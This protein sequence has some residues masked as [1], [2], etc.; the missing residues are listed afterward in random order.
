MK[1]LSTYINEKLVLNKNTF[2][3]VYKYFPETKEELEDILKQLIEERKD[4]D[5]IDLNDIDTSKIID[6]SQLFYDV[7]RKVN[8]GNFKKID[9]SE[10]NVSNVKNMTYM[11]YNCN[12]L[13]YIGD[14]SEWD[15]SKVKNMNSMFYK[16]IKLKYIGDLSSWDVSNVENMEAMFYHCDKLESIGDISRWDVKNVNDMEDM[17]TNSGITNLPTWYYA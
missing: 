2:K 3:K 1:Q 5:I 11:F 8:T 4:Q 17:F 13:K 14:I 12:K 6:M 9:I 10:W 16:C 15:V 7:R